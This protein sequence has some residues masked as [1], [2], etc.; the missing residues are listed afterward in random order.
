[1]AQLKTSGSKVSHGLNLFYQLELLFYLKIQ[2]YSRRMFCNWAQSLGFLLSQTLHRW[3]RPDCFITRQLIALKEQSE[4]TPCT[5][6][7]H[8]PLKPTLKKLHL[9]CFI[10][11]L[12]SNSVTLS[13]IP[14]EVFCCCCLAL[15]L[16]LLFC[17][18]T[19]CLPSLNFNFF[20]SISLLCLNKLLDNDKFWGDTCRIFSNKF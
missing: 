14:E 9:N 8:S 16:L 20:I 4:R 15:L 18:F 12:R 1:M 13:H 11:F 5:N 17:Y 2:L 6:T 7:I 19:D 10:L 3:D